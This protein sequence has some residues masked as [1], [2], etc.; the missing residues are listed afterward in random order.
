[1][2]LTRYGLLDIKRN[3]YCTVSTISNRDA[4]FCS[5]IEYALST[6]DEILWMVETETEAEYVRNH[7]TEW[8]NAGY[9]TPSHDYEPSEL[10]VITFTI[11]IN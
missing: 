10:K 5:D 7:K 9:R 8:F 2:K 6:L 11:E 1:M 3:K 4:E